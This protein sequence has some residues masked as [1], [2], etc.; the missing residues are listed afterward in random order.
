MQ[1]ATQQRSE[2]G[3]ALQ[4]AAHDLCCPNLCRGYLQVRERLR[5]ES[6]RLGH[7]AI[8]RSGMHIHEVWEEGQAFIDIE[9]RLHEIAEQKAQTLC[10][11]LRHLTVDIGQDR[12]NSKLKKLRNAQKKRN[13]SGGN[14]VQSQVCRLFSCCLRPHIPQGTC[15]ICLSAMSTG[16]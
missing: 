12:I 15:S 10:C 9:N 3:V 11:E 6:Y 16:N 4:S 1:L 5:R 2:V 7:L 8:S 14:S 13:A